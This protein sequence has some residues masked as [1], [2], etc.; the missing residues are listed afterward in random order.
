MKKKIAASILTIALAMAPGIL[1]A[2]PFV[3]MSIGK[4]GLIVFNCD[5]ATNGTG[6]IEIYLFG[7][8]IVWD[9]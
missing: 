1:N 4:G 9:N 5:C 8:K 6:K 2:A 3:S 7:V